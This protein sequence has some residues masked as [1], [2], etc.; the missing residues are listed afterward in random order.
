M[1]YVLR[2]V[3][4]RTDFIIQDDFKFEAVDIDNYKIDPLPVMRVS[5]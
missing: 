3:P 2:K 4:R 1:M 5:E